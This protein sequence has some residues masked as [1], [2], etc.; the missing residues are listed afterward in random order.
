MLILKIKDGK[1]F[2]FFCF[3]VYGDQNHHKLFFFFK[4][5]IFNISLLLF[6]FYDL[7]VLAMSAI[8]Y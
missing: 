1:A 4:L 6:F 8:S 3:W 2:N 5:K 7:H